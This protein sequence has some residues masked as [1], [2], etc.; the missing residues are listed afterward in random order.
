M[1]SLALRGPGGGV[2]TSRD[3]GPNTRPGVAAELG[4]CTASLNTKPNPLARSMRLHVRFQE[5]KLQ[6]RRASVQ[7]MRVDP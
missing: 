1:A 5:G 7:G 6:D 2:I 4:V 3:V